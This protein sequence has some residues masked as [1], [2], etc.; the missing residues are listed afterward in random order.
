MVTK[1][2]SKAS[3]GT[4]RSD[5]TKKRGA[6]TAKTANQTYLSRLILVAGVCACL[7]ITVLA[8]YPVLREYYIVSR[9]NEQLNAELSAVLD[10]NDKIAAQIKALNTVE[11]IENRAREQFGWV[12]AGEEAVNIT[13]LN[14]TDSTTLLPQ[15]ITPGEIKAQTSWWTDF[16]DTLFVVDTQESTEP[17]PDPFINQ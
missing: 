16:L 11:G 3:S 6:R 10:R 12:K 1:S 5:G 8:L 2:Y 4:K 15:S 13:G 14:I 9:A 17:I 7:V